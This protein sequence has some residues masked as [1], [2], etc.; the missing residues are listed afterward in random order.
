MAVYLVYRCS[1]ISPS[2]R[3]IRRFEHDN[4]VDWARSIWK[5]IPN[6]EDA[7]RYDREVLGDPDIGVLEWMFVAIAEEGLPP[8]ESTGDV[9]AAL[10][11]NAYAP[12]EDHG[13]HHIQV[14]IEGSDDQVALYLFDD[15]FRAENPGL[16]DFLLLDGWELPDAWSEEESPS[17][18]HCNP[19]EPRGSG[20]GTLYFVHLLAE[21]KY[22]LD[23]LEDGIR[24][25][26]VRVED[27][28]RYALTWSEAEAPDFELRMLRRSLQELLAAPAGEDAG[29]LSA[30]RD[31]PGEAVHW[32]VYSDWR[33]EQGKPPAGLHLLEAAL[34]AMRLHYAR[35]TC[36][37]SRDRIKV[38]PHMAQAYKH[39]GVWTS[40]PDPVERE[41]YTQFIF[42]DDRWA[43]A[44][45]TLAS[46]ILRFAARWDV[47]A[48]E[49]EV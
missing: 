20:E 40:Y 45:P 21:S 41:S 31:Q 49:E 43:A 34:R 5:P 18:P 35:E 14:L 16:T 26:G 38:T 23:D 33:Q 4:I 39:E 48:T 44:N 47:L 10:V 12:E 6:E 46:G 8:P 30:I 19:V 32:A 17:L 9:L 3:F 25:D 42:F 7:R 29:F 27:V 36:D 13:E 22:N 15:H 11:S 2:E 24:L 37:P 1:E 28:C